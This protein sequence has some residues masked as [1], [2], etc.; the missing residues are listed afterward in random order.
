MR[1]GMLLIYAFFLAITTG[2]YAQQRTVSPA[3]TR[4][5]QNPSVNPHARAMDLALYPTADDECSLEVTVFGI[6]DYWGFVSG[7][8]EFGDKEKAQTLEYTANVPFKVLGVIGFFDDPG[9]VG[10][11]EVTARVYTVSETDGAPD[12]LLA[13]SEP[14]FVADIVPPTDTSVELTLF[15]L[16]ED[17]IPEIESTTF[18][19]S[20]DFSALYATSDTLTLLHTLEE[21]GDGTNTWEK[22]SDDTWSNIFSSW[23]GLNADFLLGA[24]VEFDDNTTS[25]DQPIQHRG[26][27]L[28]PASPNPASS[29][30]V[31]N[32]GL[33]NAGPVEITIFDARGRALQKIRHH[34]QQAGR[35]QE[36]I[37]TRDLAP[38]SYY[39]QIT[40]GSGRLIS[41]LMVQR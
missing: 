36:E 22:F 32:Y 7:M 15:I 3:K 13:T 17:Q 18:I 27:E 25:A 9:L 39:Y 40:A 10:N 41:T 35:H 4:T 24:V 38:G 30:T 19:V 14:L 29:F 34:L 1:P 20:I 16:P 28:Y 5:L 11:G 26:L 6:T 37:H 31:L 8:N 21:C 12:Q 33:E 23:S 2:V